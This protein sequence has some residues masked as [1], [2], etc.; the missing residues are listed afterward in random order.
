M[1]HGVYPL[2]DFGALGLFPPFVKILKFLEATKSEGFGG[3]EGASFSRIDP[4]TQI[5]NLCSQNHNYCV[6]FSLLSFLNRY[7]F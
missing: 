3:Y 2:L 7:T 6:F 4:T 1:I 5:Q